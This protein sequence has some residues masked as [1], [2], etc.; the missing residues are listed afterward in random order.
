MSCRARLAPLVSLLACG[1]TALVFLYFPGRLEHQAVDAAG[2]NARGTGAMTGFSISPGLAFGEARAMYAGL[3]GAG[4]IREAARDGGGFLVGLAILLAG[5]MGVVGIGGAARPLASLTQAAERVARGDLTQQ[6]AIEGPREVRRLARAFNTIAVELSEARQELL[7]AKE[8]AAAANVAKSEFLANMSHEIRTPMNSVSGML[9]LSL[10][11]DLSPE[12]RGFLSIASASADSLL[13]MIDDIFD[14]ATI[15]AGM[16]SLA[17]SPFQ[18][19]ECL[20]RTVGAM[21]P[22]AREK[23]LALACR[24]DPKVPDALVGD[25]PT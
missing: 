10:D 1:V 17:A 9:E 11:T 15:E 14:F 12:Q 6:A 25:P 24:I 7:A 21:A 20:D 18:L 5:A 4:R 3:Q 16:R 19:R 8:S 23:G 22:R 2:A 13:G